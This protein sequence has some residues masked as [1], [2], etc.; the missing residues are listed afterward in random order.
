M[1]SNRRISA[2]LGG[3]GVEHV[4]PHAGLHRDHAQRVGH[5]VVQL[6]RD[7]Q[8]L[9]G[10]SPQRGFGAL[11]LQRFDPLSAGLGGPTDEH[12]R[13]EGRGGD[14]EGTDT[15]IGD[16][17]DEEENEQRVHGRGRRQHLPER[18]IGGDGVGA[19]QDQHGQGAF[20][21]PR[22]HQR[23]DGGAT[24]DEDRRKRPR[25]RSFQPFQHPPRRCSDRHTVSVPSDLRPRI[26][27]EAQSPLCRSMEA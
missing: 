15:E 11:V 13:P 6:L 9:V 17:G 24:P 16:V 18:P 1:P 21:V 5:D 19:E 2:R 22:Q 23:S 12:R 4:H 27:L 3:I 8:T 25:R 26:G 10:R 14:G 20:V 7:A